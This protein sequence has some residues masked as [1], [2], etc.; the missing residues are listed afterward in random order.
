[1]FLHRILKYEKYKATTDKMAPNCI[2]MDKTEENSGSICRQWLINIKWPVD[3]MG[4]NSVHPSTM[5]N[6]RTSNNIN[7]LPTIIFQLWFNWL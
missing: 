4:K 2:D 3:D 7:D 6:N 5:L 1:M